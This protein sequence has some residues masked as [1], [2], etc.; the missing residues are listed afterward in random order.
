MVPVVWGTDTMWHCQHVEMQ[1]HDA[2]PS[3]R[4][5]EHVLADHRCELKLKLLL[6]VQLILGKKTARHSELTG[7]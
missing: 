4:T 6:S 1:Q 5:A 3:S 2:V 7:P